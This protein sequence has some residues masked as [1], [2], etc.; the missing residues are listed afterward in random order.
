[1]TKIPTLQ[2]VSQFVALNIRDCKNTHLKIQLENKRGGYDSS[3]VFNGLEIKH[4]PD[5]VEVVEGFLDLEDYC[6]AEDMPLR[7]PLEKQ[8]SNDTL[9][10]YL[11]VGL[12]LLI[13]II[14]AASA[15]ACFL[16][17]NKQKLDIKSDQDQEKNVELIKK[18]EW[19]ELSD[20]VQ[21]SHI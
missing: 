8:Q 1:M 6:L 21:L 11:L 9:V 20:Q 5:E 18:T 10:A 17:K 12:G 19:S 15:V 14:G 13:L 4:E 7:H 3:I 16:S 2:E